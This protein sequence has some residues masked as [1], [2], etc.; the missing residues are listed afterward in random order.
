MKVRVL[1]WAITTSVVIAAREGVGSG[2]G[3]TTSVVI[4]ARE[5][6]GSGRALAQSRTADYAL[7]PPSAHSPLG[8]MLE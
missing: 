6:A 7:S 8:S 4:A 1:A 5:G 2:M 3:F